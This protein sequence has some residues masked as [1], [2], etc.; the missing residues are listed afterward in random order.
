[1][2][3]RNKF[4]FWFLDFITPVLSLLPIFF[5]FIFFLVKGREAGIEY[6]SK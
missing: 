4:F 1:M 2:I 3:C 5:F 6:T